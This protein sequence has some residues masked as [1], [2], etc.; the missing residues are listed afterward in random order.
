MHISPVVRALVAVAVLVP[1]PA[2]SQ[3]IGT[4]QTVAPY[5]TTPLEGD[6]NRVVR[7]QLNTL[8]PG[9]SG[10]FHR[11]PGDQWALIQEG[12]VTITIKG[13]PPRLLKAGD[14]IY[15]PRGTIHRNQNLGTVTSRSVE[16]L[17]VDKDKP[18]VEPVRD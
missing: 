3:S 8:V 1:S 11:H 10:A 6:P 12:E 18:V 13:E 4:G 5:L 9:G 17:V 16:V 2:L 15:I 7:M 14:S